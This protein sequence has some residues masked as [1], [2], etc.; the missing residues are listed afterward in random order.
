MYTSIHLT[1][2]FICRT[3]STKVFD[4]RFF[5]QFARGR[6]RRLRLRRTSSASPAPPSRLLSLALLL[7]RTQQTPRA[8]SRAPTA[9]PLP[10]PRLLPPLL[11]RRFSRHP[12][13]AARRFA[14]RRRRLP[15][16]TRFSRPSGT[17]S[18]GP[19]GARPRG[20]R[21]SGW[22]ASVRGGGT[23]WSSRRS[24]PGG[25]PEQKV[26]LDTYAYTVDTNYESNCLAT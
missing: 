15:A 17:S 8:Q 12:A 11:A 25:E 7:R 6:P 21:G 23:A 3:R 1:T 22:T 5:M 2:L 16:G 9:H 24:S 19:W 26:T 14:R 4:S 10:W 18:S 13:R 20:T